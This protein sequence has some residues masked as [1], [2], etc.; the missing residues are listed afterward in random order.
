MKM[1]YVY[2]I[3][4]TILN[5]QYV[6]SHIFYGDNP[7]EDTYMSSSGYVHNDIKKYGIENF[8]KEI[9][10][11]DCKDK[12]EMLNEETKYILKYNTLAPNGYNY[13]LPNKNLGFHMCGVV[14]WNKG[15]KLS[16][17]IRKNMSKGQQGRK[18]SE[19]H[20]KHMSESLKGKNV[21]KK[22]SK[23]T[24]EKRKN[25][26]FPSGEQSHMHNTSVYIIW[27]EKY[28]KEI[29]EEKMKQRN[30]KASA[31][32]KKRYEQKRTTR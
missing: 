20:K 31:S 9:L 11:Y 2:L 1:F 8:K 24:L 15:A 12:I 18:Y 7:N 19:E 13:F 28:G 16:S 29:A 32:M 17:D 14:P 30:E 4:N 26:I 21:G 5:K 27:V 6:G 23:E 22:R 10:R 3:T 25:I